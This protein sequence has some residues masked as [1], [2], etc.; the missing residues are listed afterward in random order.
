MTF[1]G[2]LRFTSGNAQ[3]REVTAGFRAISERQ[4]TVMVTRRC[5]VD[6]DGGARF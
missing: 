2:M 6:N 3:T 5:L 1:R 4:G